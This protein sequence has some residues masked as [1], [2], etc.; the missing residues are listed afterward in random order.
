MVFSKENVSW[1]RRLFSRKCPGGNYHSLGD[2]D[3]YC[4]YEKEGKY[5]WIGTSWEH[6]CQ[7]CD[8][9]GPVTKVADRPWLCSTCFWFCLAMETKD[10]IRHAE[11]L[12][13]QKTGT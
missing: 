10:I 2:K 3:C 8:K 11:S 5:R 13:T 1:L 4:T 6:I 12:L 9:S 7:M